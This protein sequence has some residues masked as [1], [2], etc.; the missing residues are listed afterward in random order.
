MIEIQWYRKFDSMSRCPWVAR[1]RPA[2]CSMTGGDMRLPIAEY[3]LVPSAGWIF[4]AA[5]LNYTSDQDRP[6]PESPGHGCRDDTTTPG[7][8]NGFPAFLP[9]V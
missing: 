5:L 4:C 3:R 9:H 2:V 7:K 1:G 6:P 8:K